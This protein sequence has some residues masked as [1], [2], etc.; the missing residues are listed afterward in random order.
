MPAIIAA[1]VSAFAW[2]FK[3]HIGLFIASAL[4]W[5][6]INFASVKL[7]IEPVYDQLTAFATSGQGGGGD[8]GAAM[9]QYL[10]V[11]NFDKALTM[12]ISAVATKKALTAGRLFLFRR[13]MLP[14]GGA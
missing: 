8:L 10:G 11:L 7:V 12:I 2:M 5:I 13:G 6:G 9:W 14:G 3:S 4:V 1:I